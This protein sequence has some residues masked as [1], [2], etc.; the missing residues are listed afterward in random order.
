MQLYLDSLYWKGT[1]NYLECYLQTEELI[2]LKIHFNGWLLKVII[3]PVIPKRRKEVEK[4][5]SNFL[6]C[7]NCK[8][9]FLHM[10]FSIPCE[11]VHW[12]I[13]IPYFESVLHI[14]SDVIMQP[15][16]IG[17]IALW[18]H[19]IH[20]MIPDL[21]RMSTQLVLEFCESPK[22]RSWSTGGPQPTV[23]E[24]LPYSFYKDIIYMVHDNYF[25]LLESAT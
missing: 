11:N 4:R 10:I 13:D 5:E 23:W 7:L 8:R 2:L 17:Y 3:L 1:G 6:V 14:L 19:S 20:R 25:A 12:F 22:I 18:C 16:L 21:L 9:H 15:N 24:T